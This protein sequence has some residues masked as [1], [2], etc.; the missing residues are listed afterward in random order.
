MRNSLL[1]RT[2]L[3]ALG[4]VS[5]ACA[6]VG[7]PT[8]VT[9]SAALAAVGEDSPPS[10]VTLCKIGPAGTN[11]TFS[12]SA[13]GGELRAGSTVTVAATTLEEMS[14]CVEIWRA[15]DLTEETTITVTEV[16]ATAGTKLTEVVWLTGLDGWGEGNVGTK[17]A[18]VRA[19]W[20]N[21]GLIW[22][23]NEQVDVPPPPPPPPALAGCTPGFWRQAHHYAYWTSPYTPTT[24]FGSVFA[25][26]FPGLTLGEVVRL[27]GG[28]LNA[29]GRH[30]VAALLNAASPDVAYG[31]TP[32]QVI[33]AFNA[34]HASGN[35]S[36][37]KD[38]FEAANER[39][40]T[41]NKTGSSSGSG[42]STGGESGG[43]KPAHAGPPAG[44]GK[45]K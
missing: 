26:A 1:P 24:A 20:E 22:F 3:A 34:A 2:L 19:D 18:V 11:A 27:G 25:N 42:G 17:T 37:Q 31:M 5:V 38:V 35:Y 23:K 6:D 8:A 41:V 30:T 21:E 12:V 39:G 15:T 32:A 14:T 40:C 43:G 10:V 9:S 28:G 7:A 4:A 13:T 45:N 36:A 16:S 44:K 33:A 29:L